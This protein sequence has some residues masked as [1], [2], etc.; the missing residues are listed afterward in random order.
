MNRQQILD[1]YDWETGVCFRHPAKGPVLTAHIATVRPAAG[2]L[3]DLRACEDCV[4]A[5]EERRAQANRRC[6]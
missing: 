5:M 6:R 3:Q 4:V 1:L 2:G